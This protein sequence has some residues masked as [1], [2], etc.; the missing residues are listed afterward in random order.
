MSKF[1][2]GIVRALSVRYSAGY[3]LAAHAHDWHQLLH[4]SEGVMLVET[5]NGAWIVPPHRAVWLPA[6]TE[7]RITMRGSVAMKTLY[8][9]RDW[10]TPLSGTCVIELSPLLRELV[11]HCSTRGTLDVA[12]AH[13]ERLAGLLIDLLRDTG[14]APLALPMPRDERAVRVANA[15]RRGDA[16]EALPRGASTRTI[17]RLFLAETGM[18][19][20]RWRQ[21]ARLLEALA[22]LAE[23]ASVTEVALDV[24]YATPSAFI[25]MFK[26]V[27]GTTPNRYFRVSSPS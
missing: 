5:E 10:E 13:D 24:G 12:N 16:D 19:L 2:Q 6:Q 14:A 17:E 26:S 21:Q 11:G 9:A 23:G 7:H 8:F 22:R 18:T 4:A 27:L 3:V 1:R 15:I 25:T 20:G